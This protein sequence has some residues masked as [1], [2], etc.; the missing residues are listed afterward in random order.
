[1]RKRKERHTR[2]GVTPTKP[3]TRQPTL[4]YTQTHTHIYEGGGTNRRRRE[5]EGGLKTQREKRHRGC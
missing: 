4:K 2:K 5:R 3:T 1:M